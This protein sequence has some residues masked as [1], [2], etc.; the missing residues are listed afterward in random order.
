MRIGITCYDKGTIALF[1]GNVS[2]RR[3]ASTIAVNILPYRWKTLFV[4]SK[5]R[6]CCRNFVFV[7]V[8]YQS[9]YCRQI[10]V[11]FLLLCLSV[12]WFIGGDCFVRF[13]R[14]V[15]VCRRLC[16]VVVFLLSS[17]YHCG[18]F[19]LLLPCQF[20][21][22]TERRTPWLLEKPHP[23]PSHPIPSH[24]IPSHPIPSHPIVLAVLKNTRK[25]GR[26]WDRGV[27]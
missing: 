23:I 14:R 4:F 27:P 18:N 9:I 22:E 17:V 20:R 2:D 13:F 15:E 8:V 19:A 10:I 16:A 25:D 11:D 26:G 21:T 3:V 6:F 24:P 7:D 5:L 1:G 12:F